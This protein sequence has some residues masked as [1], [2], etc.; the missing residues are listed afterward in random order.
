M[1][2]SILYFHFERTLTDARR[3]QA[4]TESNPF[5]TV[6]APTDQ[7]H[8]TAQPS[9]T[10]E[11][12]HETDSGAPSNQSST[13]P[14][15]VSSPTTAH[16]TPPTLLSR[17]AHNLAPSS[18]KSLALPHHSAQ[19]GTSSQSTSST[20]PA[21]TNIRPP[22]AVHP[23]DQ[24][25]MGSKAARAA[26]SQST[27]ALSPTT[28]AVVGPRATAASP[29]EFLLL[30]KDHQTGRTSAQSSTPSA[31]NDMPNA[32]Q[33]LPDSTHVSAQNLANLSLENNSSR[34]STSPISH[35]SALTAERSLA[36]ASQVQQNLAD[37]PS[38]TSA[39]KRPTSR[40]THTNNPNLQGKGLLSVKLISAR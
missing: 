33:C 31:S 22:S 38:S 37:K 11:H 21:S 16:Q 29:S 19:H 15:L 17:L 12:T 28:I 25:L 1:L 2:I 30:D 6:A 36:K 7:S 39:P 3:L 18:L 20:D 8:M 24:T 23:L 14:R 9:S 13:E 32:V 35:A 40:R 27:T 34:P 4:A 26:V 10:R 5:D